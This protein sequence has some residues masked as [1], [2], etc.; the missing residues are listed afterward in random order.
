MAVCMAFD[1]GICRRNPPRITR[2]HAIIATTGLVALS[3]KQQN[4]LGDNVSR[5][6]L[7]ESSPKGSAIPMKVKRRQPNS[8][9]F[10]IG[11]SI[12]AHRLIMGM[13]QSDLAHKLGVSF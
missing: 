5:I 6:A 9:D 10:Q 11:K 13:S 1:S 4:E 8:A 2:S 12:R 3:T 7:P